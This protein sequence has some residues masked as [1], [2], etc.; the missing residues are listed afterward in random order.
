M[1]SMNQQWA[2]YRVFWREFRRSFQ[3][4][5]AVLPSGPALA[6]ALSRYV[7]DGSSETE[8]G[9][10]ILEVGPGTGAVTRHILAD[11]RAGDRLDLVERNAEFVACLRERMSSDADY[12][13]AAGRITL[14]HAGVEELSEAEP[15]DVI[16]SG[17]PLN[18]FS[19]ELVEML[20]EK[21]RRLLAPAGTLSFFEYVAIRRIKAAVSR[22]AE[23]ERLKRIGQVLDE[24]LAAHEVRRDRVLTNVP[25]AWVHHVRFVR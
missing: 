10:R 15:Y 2:D 3:T 8:L 20:I 25:P 22:Q 7:R 21:L 4:T 23:R 1:P 11:L 5:G 16:I 12:R 14:H 17:L 13:A 18:N 9:R 6:A 24:V 19:I